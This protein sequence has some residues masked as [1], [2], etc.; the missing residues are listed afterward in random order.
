MAVSDRLRRIF[1]RSSFSGGDIPPSGESRSATPE[2]ASALAARLPAITLQAE[3][4]A[5]S[6]TAGLHGQRRSGQGESFWQYRPAQPGEPANRI[7]WRQSARSDRAWVRETEAES[8][9]TVLL[10]CDLSASMRWRSADVLPEK[11]D[12]ALLMLLAAGIALHRGGERV[13]LLSPDGP[14]GL[15][16][17]GTFASRLAAGWAMMADAS[18]AGQHSLP[19][20]AILPRNARLVVASDFLC[21]V[22]ETA[23]FLQH[24]TSSGNAAH[25]L[26]IMDPAEET[27]PWTGHMRFTGMEG[28]E[29]VVLPDV[30]A[31]R[32]DY[33]ALLQARETL[34]MRHATES[35]HGIILHR[36]DSAPETA[37]L[38][39]HQQMSG[40]F[41][42]G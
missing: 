42:G 32:A 26:Q 21:T 30:S 36:T 11:Q 17:G 34:L 9:G 29:A 2:D 7:D 13:R 12:R 20:Q 6:L 15:P 41:S 35:G 25:L 5:A 38:T 27:L 14:A 4:I 23:S 22:E 3:R 8:A 28:E 1:R 24:V 31:M 18:G 39:L 19:D 33:E 16:P 37:L 40:R 10:W